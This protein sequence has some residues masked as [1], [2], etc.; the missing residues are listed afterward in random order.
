MVHPEPIEDGGP[1][2]PDRGVIQSVPYR[3]D[4]HLSAPGI[5]YTSRTAGPSRLAVLSF[6]SV[7]GIAGGLIWTLGT[8]GAGL[9]VDVVTLL[10][11]VLYLYS[12]RNTESG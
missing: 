5:S 2:D 9:S 7:G 12:Q 6:G 3:S 10:T 11:L 1:V 8:P 4:T